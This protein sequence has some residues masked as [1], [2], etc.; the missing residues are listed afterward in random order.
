[1]PLMPNIYKKLKGSKRFLVIKYPKTID[2]NVPR[3]GINLKAKK[4]IRGNR[5]KFIDGWT[6]KWWFDN[7]QKAADKFNSL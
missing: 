7:G 2:K 6:D 3:K 4:A 1:M 5:Q